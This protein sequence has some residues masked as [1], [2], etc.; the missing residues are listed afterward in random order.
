MSDPKWWVCTEDDKRISG[1]YTTRDDA[2]IARVWVERVMH[3]A[4]YWVKLFDTVSDVE[5]A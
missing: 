4:T 5:A 1:P 3:P 2:L